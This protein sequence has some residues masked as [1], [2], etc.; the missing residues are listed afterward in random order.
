V[1][2][3]KLLPITIING[4]PPKSKNLTLSGTFRLSKTSSSFALSKP[5]LAGVLDLPDFGDSDATSTLC[6]PI[7][8]FNPSSSESI[9]MNE[10]NTVMA[11]K[12]YQG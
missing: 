9:Y 4:S 12:S 1:V 10:N 2:S 11:K 7:Y 5:S 6:S 8:T 3:E